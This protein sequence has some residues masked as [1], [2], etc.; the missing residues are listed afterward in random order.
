LDATRRVSVVF[1]GNDAGNQPDYSAMTVTKISWYLCALF[2]MALVAESAITAA[3]G[4]ATVIHVLLWAWAG[5]AVLFAAIAVTFKWFRF[6]EPK[7]LV[8][9]FLGVA[10]LATVAVL[11]L[12]V[13]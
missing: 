13:G 10:A 3:P 7:W 1:E 4:G 12:T 9:V 2:I 6:S 8:R 5:L 11:L